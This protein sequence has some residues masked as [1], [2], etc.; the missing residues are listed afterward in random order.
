MFYNTLV[1]ILAILMGFIIHD[2]YSVLVNQDELYSMIHN[3][4]SQKQFLD[5]K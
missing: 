4:R 1:V 3:L 5:I 2:L